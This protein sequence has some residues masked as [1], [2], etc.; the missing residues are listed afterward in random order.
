MDG[1]GLVSE[2]PS[3]QAKTI[4]DAI[5][6]YRNEKCSSNGW[7]TLVPGFSVPP[8][9]KGGFSLANV[10]SRDGVR[11]DDAASQPRPKDCLDQRFP[12][13]DESRADWNPGV[14]GD[15]ASQGPQYRDFIEAIQWQ[16][17]NC[18]TAVIRL[19]SV[20]CFGTKVNLTE[21]PAP[22]STVVDSRI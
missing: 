22:R 16:P 6:F 14:Q 15:T 7:Q 4:D 5:L 9:H 20:V 11:S 10:W 21:S 13:G 18:A 8:K 2:L 12:R 1:R 3:S 19:P 17:S